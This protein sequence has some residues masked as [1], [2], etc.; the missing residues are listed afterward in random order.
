MRHPEGP[1]AERRLRARMQAL[2]EKM[3]PSLPRE[4]RTGRPRYGYEPTKEQLS[5]R[6]KLLRRHGPRADE[7][8]ADRRQG[9]RRQMS[10][11]A[12][13]VDDWLKRN[14]ISGGDRRQGDRRQGD[15]RR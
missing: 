11:S 2:A 8:Q 6:E 1:R 9:D 10:M 13:E 5:E 14:G 4:L 3:T 12:A 7:R 15:R